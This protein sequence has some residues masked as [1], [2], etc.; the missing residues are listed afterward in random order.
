M[1]TTTADYQ[2]MPTKA[3]SAVT[4]DVT[5]ANAARTDTMKMNNDDCPLPIPPDE[6]NDVIKDNDDIKAANDD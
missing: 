2:D 1:V 5:A 3:V 4:Q 6:D